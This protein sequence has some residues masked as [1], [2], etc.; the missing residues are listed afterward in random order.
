ML[1]EDHLVLA[2]MVDWGKS[3]RDEEEENRQEKE[4]KEEEE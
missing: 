2:E 3:P 4:N 1:E